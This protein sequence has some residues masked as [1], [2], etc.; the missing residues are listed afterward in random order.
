MSRSRLLRG[1]AAGALTATCLS[2]SALAQE[3][4]PEIDIG[5]A[6]PVSGGGSGDGGSGSGGGDAWG[7]RAKMAPDSYVAPDATT[8]T[9]TDT[10]IMETPLNVQV[11]TQQVLQDQ[12]V[13]SIDQAVKNVSGVNVTPNSAMNPAQGSGITIRGFETGSYFRNGYRDDYGSSSSGGVQFANVESVEVLKGSSAILYGLVDPGGIVN[14]ITK[15]PQEKTAYYIDQQIGSFPT[16]RTTAGATGPVTPDKSVLYRVD[17]S[18]ENARTFK[19]FEH[20]DI[21]FVAPVVK[22]NYDQRTQA[23]LEFEYKNAKQ[24][25]PFAWVPTYNGVIINTPRSLNYGEYSPNRVER[26]L[27]GFNWSHQFDDDWTIRHRVQYVRT[28]FNSFDVF[29]LFIESNGDQALVDQQ[30]WP[31][32]GKYDTFSTNLDLIGHFYTGELKHTLL[33]GGEFY[34]NNIFSEQLGILPYSQ[35][36]LFNPI[37]PGVPY[38]NSSWSPYTATNTNYEEGA[39]IQD[40]IALPFGVHLLGGVR[41]QNITLLSRAGDY[42]ANDWTEN[43]P[44]KAQR[45]TPRVGVLW[46]PRE[47]LS[48]YGNYAEGFGPNGGQI[49]PGTPVPPSDATQYEFGAKAEFFDSKLRATA[50]YFNITKTN[51]PT[52]DLAHPGFQLITGEVNAK[53]VEFDVQGEVLPGWNIILAYANTE[54]RITKANDTDSNGIST[55]GSRFPNVPRNTASGFSS[56]E[57]KQGDFKGLKFGGGVTYRDSQRIQDYG[58]PRNQTDIASYATVDT[59]GAYSFNLEGRK[60]TLQLN[61]NNL[62]DHKYYSAGGNFFG[63]PLPNQGWSF[64]QRVV[65]EP[66]AFKG[67]LRMEF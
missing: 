16:F 30:A 53:G 45:V 34:R 9:R 3:A 50:A 41:Y 12:Q 5:V 2:C 36:N 25:D 8:G 56:Y 24:S 6:R 67:S 61:V 29:P 47:W 21:F 1:V 39:Y 64:T 14:I 62:L 65:G 57:F 17:F 51:V 7:A 33:L 48:L 60:V 20:G 10:P 37:H 54:T 31:I 19:E 27:I 18:Y 46:Q 15:Q 40:Q 4:L 38:L 52:A 42:K 13:Y 32:D 35:I 49:F 58:D 26:A 55:V 44:T 43:T 63:L 11:V 66:R 23:T 59:F 28:W 22:W